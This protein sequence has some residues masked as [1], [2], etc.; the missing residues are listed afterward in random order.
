VAKCDL[1]GQEA[2]L[3]RKRHKECDA[4]LETG[5]SEITTLVAESALAS[6]DLASLQLE[7]MEIGQRS[8][9][10]AA[11]REPLIIE[12]W[13]KAVDVAL[14]DGVL[15]AEEEQ[16]LLAFAECFSLTQHE[17]DQDGSFSRVTKAA[18]IRDILEGTLP[19]RISVVGDLPF[20]LQKR[21]SIVWLFPST[22]YYEQR[23]RTHYE[24]GHRGVSV[25]V[26]KGV[27]YRVGGFKGHPVSTTEMVDMG[28]GPLGIT[29]R[30]IYFA[31][32]AKAFRVKYDKIVAFT[33]YTDGIGI[34]RD[35]QT[36]KPQVFLT[37]DGWFT[38]NLVCN[39]AK[40]SGDLVRR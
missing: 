31:G 13:Q 23:V 21:E 15:S 7:L 30:H 6:P 20:N 25:R 14:E 4:V 28:S 38:Y 29:D 12:G 26:A 19:E 40:A 37:G 22:T 11:D 39:L 34:Q 8:F 2:G 18:V 9:L 17:L 1:C 16:S 24:G 33:P 3:F 10:A 5:K 36:A 27:Y 35:A 32:P